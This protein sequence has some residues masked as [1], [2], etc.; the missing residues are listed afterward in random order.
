MRILYV[1]PYVPSL[2]RVR[3]YNLIRYLARRGHQVTVL[4]LRSSDDELADAE[5]LRAEG[6]EVETVFLSRR[7][8]LLNC[9]RALPT[10]TPLQAAY[11]W[12]SAMETRLRAL[13]AERQF[14]L[15][16]VE[17]LRGAHFGAAAGGV[18]RVYD[19][20]DCISLLFDRTRR[21][22]PRWTSRLMAQVELGRTQRYEARLLAMYDAVLVTSRDDGVA[23]ER[24]GNRFNRD[25]RAPVLVLTNGVDLDYFSPMDVPRAP[26]SLVFSGKMSYHANVAAV[27][28]LA[29]EIMPLVWARRPQATLTLVGQNP[30]PVIRALAADPR[31]Q[32]TGYVPDIRPYLA[33]ATVSV[34]PICYGVG[35]QNKVLEAMAMATPVVTTSQACG[36]L[37]VHDGEHLL[38][39]E[40]ADMLAWQIERVLADPALAD[41]LGRNGRRYV[42]T[43]HD[44]Q[45]VTEQLEQVYQRTIEAFWTAREKQP[46]FHQVTQVALTS[47]VTVT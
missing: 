7:D 45:A 37:Q 46:V 5:A 27:L 1:T 14:D 21:E 2:I 47:K 16:H 11:C 32:V 22:S 8:S 24:L 42:E 25:R 33:R 6:V 3:P 23:L 4:A 26:E 29:Q 43:H 19:S 12:S 31:I 36:A 28:Y 30:P 9:V 10:R 41:N 34:N 39:A 35:V 17:H 38:V 13:M 18:P 40:G 44:W 20:V 15:V